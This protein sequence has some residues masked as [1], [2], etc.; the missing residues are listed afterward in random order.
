MIPLSSIIKTFEHQLYEQFQ[1]RILPSHFKAL[2]AMKTCR[3]HSGPSMLA[4]CPECNHRESIPHSCGHRSCPH[5]QAHESQQWIDRQTKKL[6]PADY[7][8]LTFT[9][10]VS[11]RPLAWRHQRIVYALMSQ[12][13]WATVQ[14]FSLNDKQL[15]GTPGATTVLHTHSR[16]L[17]YHPHIHMIIPAAAVDIQPR[18]WR[19]KKGRGERRYLFNHKALAKVFRAKLLHALARAELALPKENPEKWVVDC[20]AVGSGEKALAYLGR[21]LYRGVIAEKNIVACENDRVTFRYQN[22]K[23]KKTEYRTVSGVE[24]L[25]LILQ[26]ILPRGF[27]RTRDYGFL[28]SNS[29]RL[30]ELIQYLLAAVVT[31]NRVL[32]RERPKLI[33]RCCGGAMKILKTRVIP[34]KSVGIGQRTAT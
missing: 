20:K 14:Q 25:W 31:S 10:P 26:H 8:L 21:Y 13:A 12:C 6:V 32:S 23:T 28:H 17:D 7:F 29:K 5:C 27:R 3:S 1:D 15:H 18:Q 34:K 16:R 11:F 4:E 19:V 2:T 22:S 33:C 30:I 9:L 24:F